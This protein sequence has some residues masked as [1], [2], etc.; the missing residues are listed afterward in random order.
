MSETPL[1]TLIDGF[2]ALK[3]NETFLNELMETEP[4]VDE[5]LKSLS[6]RLEKVAQVMESNVKELMELQT[7]VKTLEIVQNH[8]LLPQRRKKFTQGFIASDS[9]SQ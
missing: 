8:L 5:R 1:S 9:D 6:E 4:T 7:R 3:A 2:A